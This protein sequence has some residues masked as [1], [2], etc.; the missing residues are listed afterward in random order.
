VIGDRYELKELVGEGG[1]GAVYRGLDRQTQQPVAIKVLSLGARDPD[2]IE[3]MVREQQ[4]MVAL[5][6]SGAVSVLDLC[7]SDTGQLCLVMEWLEG[8]DL[9]QHLSALEQK[10][11][12]LAIDRLLQIVSSVANTIDRAHQIGIVHRDI[13][14]A[15]IFLTGYSGTIRLLDFGLSR[16]KWSKTL[17]QAGMVMGSP[18]YIA[19][20]TW[21]GES[22]LVDHRADLYALGVVI[23]RA[24]SGELPFGSNSLVDQMRLVTTAA[25]PSLRQYRPDLPRTIDSWVKKALAIEPRDRFQTGR[26]LYN[27]LATALGQGDSI[28]RLFPI[29]ATLDDIQGAVS[30]AWTAAASLLKRFAAF[31]KDEGSATLPAELAR[32]QELVAPGTSAEGGTPVKDNKTH[33]GD[34]LAGTQHDRSRSPKTGIDMFSWLGGKPAAA[35]ATPPGKGQPQ[36]KKS[37]KTAKKHSS[38]QGDAKRRSQ[39]AK[40]SK[41]KRK[42]RAAREQ[43]R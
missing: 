31:G 18:S 32:T 43:Q 38:A 29:P 35:K 13:K 27:A 25:R 15:N 34:L 10:R 19:P 4:A 5:A 11:Q 9:E 26:A 2:H 23:F 7:D 16:M 42:A 41:S 14:P 24:L 20:E 8:E 37:A 40:K 6:G 21:R 1:Y 30:S 22:K 39:R 12:F 28:S 36:P 3:R 17:T 33:L